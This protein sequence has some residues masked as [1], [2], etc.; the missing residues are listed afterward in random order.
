MPVKL[1]RAAPYL[2][3]QENEAFE[4]LC[5]LGDRHLRDKGDVRILGNVRCGGYEIDAVVMSERAITIID[6]KDYGGTITACENGTWVTDG[7][8]TVKGGSYRNPFEQVRVYKRGMMNWLESTVGWSD[9]NDVTHISGLALF[10]RPV[11]IGLSDVPPTVSKWFRVADFKGG[12]RW[13]RD[14]SSP[15][16]DL[17]HDYLDRI[18]DHLKVEPFTPAQIEDETSNAQAKRAEVWEILRD[19]DDQRMADWELQ[20]RDWLKE[21]AD[22]LNEADRIRF[23]KEAEFRCLLDLDLR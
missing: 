2:H 1:Y 3:T 21:Q 23:E 7:G 16:L 18:V 20:N 10:T 11:T 5:L 14:V 15:K 12:L 13:L 8:V 6:F 4:K 17:Q 19:L 9:A 22:Q